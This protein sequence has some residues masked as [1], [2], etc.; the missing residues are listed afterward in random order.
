MHLQRPAA[1]QYAS[2]VGE[3]AQQSIVTQRQVRSRTRD[4]DDGSTLVEKQEVTF[5]E[6]KT[7]W[8]AQPTVVKSEHSAQATHVV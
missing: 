3:D 7:T 8:L 5:T 1:S 6:T 4:L 2:D